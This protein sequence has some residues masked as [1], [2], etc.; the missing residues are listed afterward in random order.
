MLYCEKIENHRIGNRT[1]NKAIAE[2]LGW[3]TTIEES[4][5]ETA[6]DG[7]LWEKGF[8]PKKPLEE[9]KQEKRAEINAACEQARIIEGAEYDDDLFDIDETS[10]SNILAQIKVAE[11]LNNAKATY[12]Y[13]SKT[14]QNHSFTVTQLQ[15]LGLAIAQKVN[16]IYQKSWELKSQV[17]NA[18]TE[19]ELNKITW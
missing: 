7:S 11:L 16:E 3:T 18:K 8:A 4:K 1:P 17:D 12:I 19:D 10:Q 6:Y 9:L 2:S 13:R 15:E 5:T 14:N